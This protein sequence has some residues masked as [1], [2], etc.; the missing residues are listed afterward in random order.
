ME[1]KFLIDLSLKYGLSSDQLAKLV[2]VG[3]QAGYPD[4]NSRGFKRVLEYIC[5]MKL[6]DTPPEELVEELRRKKIDADSA[7]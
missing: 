6:T 2:S 4:I 7:N 3:H 5:E 1:N